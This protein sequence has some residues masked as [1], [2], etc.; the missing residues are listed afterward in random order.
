MVATLYPGAC[1]VDQTSESVS[2]PGIIVEYNK[3]TSKSFS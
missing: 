2:S 1:L 3:I